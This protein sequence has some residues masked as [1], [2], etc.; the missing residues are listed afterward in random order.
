MVFRRTWFV[1]RLFTLVC[2][3]LLGLWSLCSL[4]VRT[5]DEFAVFYYSAS[6]DYLSLTAL[7]RLLE[8]PLR[9]RTRTYYTVGAKYPL[10]NIYFP[11]F[12]V[13]FNTDHILAG[14]S[15]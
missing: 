8:R 13:C 1:A 9:R 2:R 15:T 11:S 5:V 12:K 4:S 14:S 3:S 6:L 10:V 7:C